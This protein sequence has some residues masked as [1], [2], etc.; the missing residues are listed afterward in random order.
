MKF[1][2]RLLSF[3]IAMFPTLPGLAS[4]QKPQLFL[5]AD[6]GAFLGYIGDGVD[7]CSL[8]D[9]NCVWSDKGPYGNSLSPFSIFNPSSSHYQA[10]CF[11]TVNT[12]PVSIMIQWDE[13]TTEFYD[14]IWPYSETIYGQVFWQSLCEAD[15]NQPDI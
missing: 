8:E 10:T 13:S 11:P 5:Q 2:M 12:L 3:G 6:N 15:S 4:P 14:Y 1:L 9:P 7:L